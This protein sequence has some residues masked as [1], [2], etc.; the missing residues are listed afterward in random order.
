MK[1]LDRKVR[2][3]LGQTMEE[4]IAFGTAVVISPTTDTQ[5]L[6]KLS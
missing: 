3:E 5:Q 4:I 2:R 1:V 6:V